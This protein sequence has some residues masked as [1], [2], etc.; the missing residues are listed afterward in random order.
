MIKHITLP[1]GPEEL[2]QLHAGDVVAISGTLYTARDAAHKRM[3]EALDRGEDLPFD[4]K[5]QG[6]YYLGPAP[7]KPGQVIGSAGPTSSYRMDRYTPMLLERGLK[8][9]IGKG[10][11]SQAVVDAMVRYGAVYFAATGGAAALLAKSI[12]DCRVVAYDDLGTEAIRKLMLNDLM[13]TVAIDCYGVDQYNRGP[14]LYL[15]HKNYI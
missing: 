3:A 2:R 11:R 6:V 4:V 10:R 12:V 14:E 5:G 1:I 9:M 8:V 7:A 13:A 15:A